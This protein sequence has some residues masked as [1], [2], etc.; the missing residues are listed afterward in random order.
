MYKHTPIHPH[1]YIYIDMYMPAQRQ[2]PQHTEAGVVEAIFLRRG[3][4]CRAFLLGICHNHCCKDRCI[5][6]SG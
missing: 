1:I 5:L 4:G 2:V 6:S 3:I